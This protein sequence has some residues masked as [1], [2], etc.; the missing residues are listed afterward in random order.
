[1]VE[2]DKMAFHGH[3]IFSDDVVRDT[4]KM[5]TA[6]AYDRLFVLVDENTRKH[7]WPILQRSAVLRD[8]HLVTIGCGDVCKTLD[9]VVKVWRTLGEHGATRHSCMVCLGGGMV[10]DLGGFA[11]STFKRGIDFINV[12]TTLLAQVDASVG[13]KTGFN[14]G[15]LKNEIGLFSESRSVILSTQFLATLDRSELLSGYAEMVKHA[16]ISGAEMWRELATFDI[17]HPD[18][19]RL[20]RLVADSVAVKE[21]IVAEDPTEKGLRRALNL[22]HTIGHAFESWAMTKGQPVPHGFA[23]AYGLVCELYLSCVKTGFPIDRLRQVAAFVREH[24]GR[25]TYTCDDYAELLRLMRH[26]KKNTAGHINFTLL[27]D[28]GDVRINQVATEKEITEAL[29][30]YRDGQ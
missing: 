4:E 19:A 28:L 20:Q 3:L 17:L 16:L 29:D 2:N 22:G 25:I 9:T 26:D 6:C 11:V 7:C 23:V 30:F 15:G 14:F 8:A 27:A 5:V 24:Y 18:W 1:M 10:T 13:G 21:R 12:P